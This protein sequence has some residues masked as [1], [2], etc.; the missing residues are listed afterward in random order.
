M[1]DEKMKI[2]TMLEEGKITAKEAQD[3]LA[4]L[5][6]A[7]EAEQATLPALVKKSLRVRINSAKGD[8]VDIRIPIK[9]LRTG[10]MLGGLVPGLDE[11]LKAGG[12]NLDLESLR[13]KSSEEIARA[14]EDINV[15]IDS[16]KGDKVIITCE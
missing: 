10:A 15:N 13:G 16:A 3:L 6:T 1:T 7:A 12:V 2:L 14:L 11:K 8:N 4:S 5:D 9:L